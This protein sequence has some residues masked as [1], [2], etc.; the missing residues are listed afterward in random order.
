M[1]MNELLKSKID[2]L[3]DANRDDMIEDIARLVAIPSITGNVAENR[4]ALDFIVSR[5]KEFGFDVSMTKECDV[6]VIDLMQ[7]DGTASRKTVGILVHV[8]VVGAGDLSKWNTN[9]FEMAVKDGFLWGRGT[10]DDKGPAILSLY[11]MK[12]VSDLGLYDGGGGNGY[13]AP[14]SRLLPRPNIRLI[15]GSSEESVWDDI[16]HYKAQ[17]DLPDCGF[18]PD[19]EFPVFNGENGYA[20]VLLTFGA[21]AEIESLNAGAAPNTIP[22]RAEIKIRHGIA[23][24]LNGVSAHSSMP[25]AGDN[26]ILKLCA[27]HP[28]FDFARFVNDHFTNLAQSLISADAVSPDAQP[29]VVHRVS[30]GIF[31]S[32]APTVL[33]KT[34]DQIHLTINIRQASGV[35][36]EHIE[37][38]F[39]SRCATYGFQYRISDYHEPMYVNPDSAFLSEMLN[40]YKA[41]GLPGEFAQARGSSYA[42]SMPNFVSWGPVLPSDPDTAHMENECLSI[43]TA[44]ISAKLYAS[45]LAVV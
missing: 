21:P 40:V 16:A 14:E 39:S 29:Q 45:Y 34:D 27:A 19:G 26:A 12:A 36:R 11:A 1:I 25:E 37:N 32:A 28:E 8:D 38:A 41:Y 2:E 7:G 43:E 3:I 20:D 18:S 6:A 13:M 30:E 35:T 4:K 5:A 10:A 42:K 15:V 31:T 9:P 44:L 17:Y 23:E 24:I 33:C 22:S